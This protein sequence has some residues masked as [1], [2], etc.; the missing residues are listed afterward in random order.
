MCSANDCVLLICQENP[1]PQFNFLQHLE[2][3]L[4]PFVN[5]EGRKGERKGGEKGKGEGKRK[6]EKRR[7]GRGKEE[8]RVDP[9]KNLMK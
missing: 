2:S 9:L 3:I 4:L 5:G 1:P 7:G 6:E 8:E